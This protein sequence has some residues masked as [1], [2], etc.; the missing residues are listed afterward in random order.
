VVIDRNRSTDSKLAVVYELGTASVLYECPLFPDMR[1]EVESDHIHN[2]TDRQDKEVTVCFH[3]AADA[4]SFKSKF[5][6]FMPQ[7]PPPEKKKGF[8][9]RLFSGSGKSKKK[10]KENMVVGKPTNFTHKSHIGFDPSSGF[11]VRIC[12]SFS[13]TSLLWLAPL[14]LI[15][16]FVL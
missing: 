4:L 11:N 6:A 5:H 9:K 12:T 10:D 13:L 2:F 3:D 15:L 16:H 1:Y 8:L 14:S 7:A